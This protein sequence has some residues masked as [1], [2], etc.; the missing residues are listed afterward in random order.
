MFAIAPLET[1]LV[2]TGIASAF[3]KKYVGI[4]EERGSTGSKGIKKSAG[5]IDS[6]YR[7]EWFVPI[8][9]TTNKCLVISKKSEKE[10]YSENG[11]AN[12]EPHECLY[13]PYTKGIAQVVFQEVP[14]FKE[15]EVTIE[16]LRSIPS[17]RQN[18]SLGSSGK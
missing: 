9:N 4:I 8:T 14:V 5:V 17:K 6:G 16:E 15:K 2:P 13:Y 18:G 11:I 7:G 3:D 1:R 12:V 10:F